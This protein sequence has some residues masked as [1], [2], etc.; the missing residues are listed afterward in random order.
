MSTTLG[1]YGRECVCVCLLQNYDDILWLKM[2]TV[3][4]LHEIEWIC[5]LQF[6]LRIKVCILCH[7]HLKYILECIIRL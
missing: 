3:L 6:W 5:L 7:R 1:D 4:G 2:I